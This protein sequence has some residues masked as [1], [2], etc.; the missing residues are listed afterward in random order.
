MKRFDVQWTAT[1]GTFSEMPGGKWVRYDE[2]RAVIDGLQALLNERDAEL[3]RL[4][5]LERQLQDVVHDAFRKDPAM[6]ARVRASLASSQ[7]LK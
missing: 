7:V 6:E 4:R 5:N 3:D 1:C 2:A